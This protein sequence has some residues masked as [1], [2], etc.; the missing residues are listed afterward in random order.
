MECSFLVLWDVAQHIEGRFF[1]WV[2]VTGAIVMF[3]IDDIGNLLVEG[4]QGD[5]RRTGF[6]AQTAVNAAACHVNG[7][8]QVEDG[9][10]RRELSRLNEIVTLKGAFFAE[11]HGAD[12]TAAITLD[13][14]RELVE[15]MPQ[16]SI[17]VKPLDVGHRKELGALAFFAVNEVIG[18]RLPAFTGLGQLMRAGNSYRDHFFRIQLVP[19]E[20]SLKTPFIAA[21]HQYSHDCFGIAAGQPEEDLVERIAR[22]PGPF[23]VSHDQSF[24][25]VG[26]GEEKRPDIAV[27]FTQAEETLDPPRF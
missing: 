8:G 16:P 4:T 21:A 5:V 15:P 3:L 7:P 17:E 2:A 10:F 18:E 20:K 13:T 14:L 11:A 27:Y 19:G 25:I 23:T 6:I 26:A 12:V 22:V 24:E 1:L 9:V